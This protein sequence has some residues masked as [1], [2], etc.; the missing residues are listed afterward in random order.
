[1]SPLAQ[2]CLRVAPVRLQCA[3][4][5]PIDTSALF[6]RPTR[7][8]KGQVETHVIA[9]R[10]VV[11]LRGADATEHVRRVPEHVVARNRIGA[12]APAARGNK[13]TDVV[14]DQSIDALR[15]AGRELDRDVAAERRA[16]NSGLS[17]TQVLEHLA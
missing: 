3:H 11:L 7:L 5:V 10:A 13:R 2:A 8:M 4:V 17:A 15:I 6:V 16:Q 1:M 12:P 9:H 14:Q